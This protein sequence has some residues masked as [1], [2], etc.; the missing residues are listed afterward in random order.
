M[1]A[2]DNAIYQTVSTLESYGLWDEVAIITYSEFGRRVKENGAKGTDHGT[3]APHFLISKSLG[4]GIVGG[5]PDLERLKNGDLQFKVDYRAMYN[6][7][8]KQN[9]GLSTNPFS[10]YDL[11]TV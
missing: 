4:S 7:V 10:T 6:F 3:A 9:F 8:L 1:S 2:L 11:P 5:F